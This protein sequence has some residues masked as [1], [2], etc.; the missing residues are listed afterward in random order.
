[1]HTSEGE[2]EGEQSLC[3]P[4][5]AFVNMCLDPAHCLTDTKMRKE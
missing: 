4:A 2:G 5:G 3:L 1:M